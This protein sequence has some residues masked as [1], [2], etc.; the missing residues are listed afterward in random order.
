MKMTIDL[1]YE[2]ADKITVASLKN[3]LDCLKADLQ[4]AKASD[5]GWI[6]HTDKEEDIKEIKKHIKAFKLV[7]KYY[8]E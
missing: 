1:E 7:L 2:Q 8:G 5:R 6:F 4:K 3:I